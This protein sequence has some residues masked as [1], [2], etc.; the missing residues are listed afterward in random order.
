MRCHN[1]VISQVMRSSILIA[2]TIAA[3]TLGGCRAAAAPAATSP[4]ALTLQPA[5][6]LNAAAATAP[7]TRTP[8]A[9]TST[10]ADPGT[11][12]PVTI[13][14]W[15]SQ[16]DDGPSGR[17]LKEM[18]A[19]F[20]ARYPWITVEPVYVGNQTDVYRKA[21]AAFQAGKPPDLAA[22]TGGYIAELMKARAVVPLDPYIADP[23]AGLTAQDKADI[24]PGY[25]EAGRYPQFARQTLSWPFTGSAL[26]MYYNLNLLKAAGAKAPPQTWADL[27][28]V[29]KAATKGDVRG[30]AFRKDALTFAGLL[31]GQGGARF[32]AEGV[33]ATFNGAEA[34][35]SLERMHRLVAA[36]SAFEPE[37]TAAGQAAFAAGRVALVLASTGDLPAYAQALKKAGA[38]FEWGCTLP[39]QK[40]A[41]SPR[42]AMDHVG[43]CV[44]QTGEARQRAAWLFIRW[45]SETD[46]AAEWSSKLGY[47]PLRRSAVARLA[48][49]G[50][51]AQNPVAKQV[52]ES[53]LPHLYAEPAVAGE[54]EIAR[55]IEDAWLAVATDLRT[56]KQALDEAV[57]RTNGILAARR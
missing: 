18:A 52:Y 39:P 50:W 33:R 31:Y 5:L 23:Q 37:S 26:A 41:A 15:H 49:T 17:L 19:R 3:L 28:A 57:V 56:P 16:R 4:P 29:C 27:E 9:P 14:F 21:L 13:V 48:N 10:P 36:G 8:L 32:D 11:P 6:A 53:V 43:L 25:W 40:N 12:Q 44:F 55:L 2:L 24:F 51:L 54:Q 46:Q 22:T 34:I 38:K 42:A 30:L 45:F 35:D 47:L 20:Q 7:P 1:K